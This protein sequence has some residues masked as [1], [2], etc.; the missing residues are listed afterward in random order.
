M[1][2]V[3]LLDTGIAFDNKVDD[4]IMECTRKELAPMGTCQYQ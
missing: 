4:I 1:E 3:L 2:N